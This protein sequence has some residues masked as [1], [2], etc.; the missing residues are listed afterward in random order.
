MVSILVAVYN[1]ADYLDAC[2]RSILSQT[3][4]D[5]EVLC[6]DDCSTD[7]SMQM[8]RRYAAE[9]NRVRIFSTR[10]NSGQA[11]ARN[12]ALEHAT[13]DIITFLDAD[14]WY[15]ADSIADIAETLRSHPEADVAL[16]DVQFATPQTDGSFA[17]RGYPMQPFDSLDNIEAARRSISWE[18]IHGWFAMRAPLYKRFPYDTTC[19]AYSDDITSTLQFLHSRGVVCSTAR[20]YYRQNADSVTHR[21]TVR[22]Y[23]ILRAKEQLARLLHKEDVP[24]DFHRRAA[25]QVW[26]WLIDCC[27]YDYMHG[28]ELSEGD[29]AYGIGELRRVWQTADRTLIDSQHLRKFGYM[30]LGLW[31]L[32]RMQNRLYFTLRQILSKNT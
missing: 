26:L 20:Y 31:P 15:D 6:V 22:R 12:I 24:E 3:L 23:D 4:R 28:G 9:D 13:G 8:L 10:R 2:L 25:T 1:A 32:F 30:H 17:L 29:R 19:K 18:G 7:D 5:I 21:A 14:D 27:Q 16:Y 11:V